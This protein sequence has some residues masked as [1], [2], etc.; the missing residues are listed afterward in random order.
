MMPADSLLENRVLR[1][2]GDW[3]GSE[4]FFAYEYEECTISASGRPTI[5]TPEMDNPADTKYPSEINSHVIQL[6]EP[7]HNME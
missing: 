6:P 5:P 1:M 2:P 7:L 3:L 4:L